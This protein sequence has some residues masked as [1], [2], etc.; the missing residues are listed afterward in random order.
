M[1]FQSN[2]LTIPRGKILFAKFAA[3]T[4][5]PGPFR[6][7]GNCPEFTLARESETLQHFSSQAGLRVM[8]E[9][10]TIDATL[11]GSVVTD[12]IKAENVAYWFMGDVST[13]TQTL[14]TAQTETHLLAKAG[15]IFQVGRS[16]GNP[17]G[18]RKLTAV[19]LTDGAT[20]TPATLVLGTDYELD[21][22]L[23]IITM[24][25]DQAKIEIAFGVAAHSRERITAGE[26]QVE[27]ELKFISYNATG[28]QGDITIPRARLSP[29]G[30]LSLVNDPEST[31][32]MTLPLNISVLKKGNLALAY[33]D[34]RAVTE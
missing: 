28:P 12:D 22:D 16:T 30:D 24:L 14:L 21:A 11:N 9:E 2:N 20:P 32:F 23:G 19:A 31:E 26:K 10:I 7:L 18:H 27:G 33:R 3:G 4:M 8:D 15:D 1:D 29:N 6:E 25:T 17:G 13:V 5:N 34:G